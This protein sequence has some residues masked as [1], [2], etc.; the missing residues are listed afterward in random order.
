M[1]R[2]GRISIHGNC[3]AQCLNW[4]FLGPRRKKHRTQLCISKKFY[5]YWRKLKRY[6]S[7]QRFFVPRSLCCIRVL[8]LLNGLFSVAS[9][10]ANMFMFCIFADRNMGSESVCVY[11]SKHVRARK[12]CIITTWQ[13]N[14]YNSRVPATPT[15]HTPYMN[16]QTCATQYINIFPLSSLWLSHCP[17]YIAN[18]CTD[19]INWTIEQ[20][21]RFRSPPIFTFSKLFA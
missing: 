5:L 21:I 9:L 10:C 4:K 15:S 14:K 6:Q 17:R 7:N 8:A 19:S 2:A 3:C 12:Y 13:I 16:I 11:S 18:N 20:A 1:F